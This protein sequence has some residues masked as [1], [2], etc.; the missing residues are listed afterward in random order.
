MCQGLF[1]IFVSGVYCRLVCAKLWVK[2]VWKGTPNLLS[3]ANLTLRV[4]RLPR[5]RLTLPL[6]RPSSSLLITLTLDEML[7]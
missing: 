4:A 1:S 5:E 7:E 2:A 6:A 3:E